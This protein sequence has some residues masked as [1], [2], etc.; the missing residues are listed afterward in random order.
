VLL[1]RAYVIVCGRFKMTDVSCGVGNGFYGGGPLI[2][3]ICERWTECMP[4]DF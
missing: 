2:V 4:P 1:K 3:E